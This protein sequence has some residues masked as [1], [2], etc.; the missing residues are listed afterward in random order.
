MDKQ[1]SFIL[2][3][4][5]QGFH[6]FVAY[7][8]FAT[9]HTDA[10]SMFQLV[11][12]VSKFTAQTRRL[13]SQRKGGSSRPLCMLMRGVKFE[14]VCAHSAQFDCQKLNCDNRNLVITASFRQICIWSERVCRVDKID[15]CS[16]ENMQSHSLSYSPKYLS[17]LA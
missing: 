14:D 11:Q 12:Y 4:A 16:S 13:K 3:L 17:S 10:G 9:K 6:T 2:P 8:A 1:H 15:K 5:S 7:L